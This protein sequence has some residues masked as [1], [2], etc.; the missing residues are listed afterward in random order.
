MVLVLAA[1]SFHTSYL[2]INPH[3]EKKQKS[4][5]KLIPELQICIHYTTVSLNIPLTPQKD[6]H[7]CSFF[8]NHV[9]AKLN[10]DIYKTI[11]NHCMD[12][13]IILQGEPLYN[14]NLSQERNLFSIQETLL[15]YFNH[16][17]LPSSTN[18]LYLDSCIN[19]FLLIFYNLI[20]H[21]CINRH[22]KWWICTMPV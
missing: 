20:T 1:F 9:V 13:Q 22:D 5:F 17:A 14:D 10:T 8:K 16:G 18:N 7:L 3:Y 12:Y 11:Q 4:I 19:H 2:P 15:L 21:W 6:I